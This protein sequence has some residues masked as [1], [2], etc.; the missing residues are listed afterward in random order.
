MT[1]KILLVDDN[2]EVRNLLRLTFSFGDYEMREASNGADALSAIT[3]WR[4]DIVLLDIMM[5]GE[6][7]GL[8]VCREVKQNP[9]I[10]HTFIIILTACGQE[11]DMHRGADAGADVYLVKPF[12]PQALSDLVAHHI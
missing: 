4:P 11:Q 1:R 6:R 8:D 5:P 10:K 9:D 2:S 12:S 3:E 7:N